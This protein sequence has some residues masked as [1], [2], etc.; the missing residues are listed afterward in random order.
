MHVIS[1]S[2]LMAP[3]WNFLADL[4]PDPALTFQSFSS[5]QSPGLPPSF[6]IRWRQDC[7]PP[8]APDAPPAADPMRS[9]SPICR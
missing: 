8:P 7:K 3:D 2:D 6:R 1:T 5:L 4:N 9:C